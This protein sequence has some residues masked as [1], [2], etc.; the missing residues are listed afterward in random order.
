MEPRRC[1]TRYVAR[2]ARASRCKYPSRRAGVAR[3]GRVRERVN[4]SN[5]QD[6]RNVTAL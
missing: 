1:S 2:R 4:V 5:I 3:G 6:E